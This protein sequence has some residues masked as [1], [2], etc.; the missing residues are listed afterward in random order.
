MCICHLAMI[1]MEKTIIDIYDY[2]VYSFEMHYIL[3]RKLH[4][5][6]MTYN[7]YEKVIKEY[8]V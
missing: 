5:G 6:H 4:L 7:V 2:S 8:M 1:F 3:L